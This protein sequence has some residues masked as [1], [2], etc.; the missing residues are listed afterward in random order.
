MDCA[1]L[2]NVYSVVAGG[3]AMNGGRSGSGRFGGYR[4]TAVNN[5]SVVWVC[6]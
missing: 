1:Q 4:G 2:E 3:S 5:N 6:S